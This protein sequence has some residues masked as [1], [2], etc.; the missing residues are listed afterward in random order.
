MTGAGNTPRLFYGWVVVGSAHLVLFT[1][2]G[3]AYSFSSYFTSLQ[4]EFQATRAATSFAF[5]ITIFVMFLT[6]VGAGIVADRTHVRWVTGFGVLCLAGGAW[7]AAQAQS[8]TG[9]YFAFGIGVG[10]GVGC[11]YVPAIAAVQPWFIKRRGLAAGIA[12]AGIGLG[13]LVGPLAAAALIQQFGWRATLTMMAGATLLLGAAALLLEK[14]PQTKGLYPDNDPTHEANLALT[15]MRFGETMVSRE[16]RLMFLAGLAMSAAQFMPFVHL[17]R[18][19]LDRGFSP[20]TGALLLGVI[21]IGSFAGRF[22][23]TGIAESGDQ[24]DHRLALA[25]L[26]GSLTLFC[27]FIL[28]GSLGSRGFDRFG[29]VGPRCRQIGLGAECGRRDDGDDRGL[30]VGEDGCALGGR[31]VANNQDFRH[32]RPTDVWRPAE[33]RCIRTELEQ[34]FLPVIVEALLEVVLQR[35]VD[36]EHER[37]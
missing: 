6:G 23:L 9:F 2:F 13:T 19:A 21:G 34:L 5:S 11:A 4:D 14:S 37:P 10:L 20:A 17:A 29:A 33:R 26:R 1:I 12:S 30:G 31:Q 18:H 8:L 3:V 16:F 24:P 27:R 22:V 32:R 15:G 28:C 36:S 35:R 25:A 7:A